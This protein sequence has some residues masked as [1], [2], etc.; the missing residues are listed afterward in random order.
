M[1]L[2]L[3]KSCSPCEQTAQASKYTKAG[4]LRETGN[5]AWLGQCPLHP[6]SSPE[7]GYLIYKWYPSF[8]NSRLYASPNMALFDFRS[9]GSRVLVLV[10]LSPFHLPVKTT[11]RQK[12]QDSNRAVWS[13]L[14][15]NTSTIMG[16]LRT[17]RQ[18]TDDGFPST[19][20]RWI[21]NCAWP[22]TVF[23]PNSF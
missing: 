4:S 13:T 9:F 20:L 2:C 16:H 6:C 22:V 3:A 14:A 12:S 1:K 11:V 7:L 8:L 19:P 17:H 5:W 21:L 18:G 10:P 15:S 23:I